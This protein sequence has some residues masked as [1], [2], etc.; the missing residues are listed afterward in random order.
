MSLPKARTSSPSHPPSLIFLI[1]PGREWGFTTSQL[2][3]S[4]SAAY[5]I[6][7]DL[8][9]AVYP[10]H[11]CFSYYEYLP[12]FHGLVHAVKNEFC[13]NLGD[14]E[15]LV[16]PLIHSLITDRQEDGSSVTC[17]SLCFSPW[18]LKCWAVL[19]GA[20]FQMGT[21]S[22]HEEVGSCRVLFAW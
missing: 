14:K 1:L 8:S 16:H 10:L 22:E 6:N 19:L 20:Q 2:L 4:F 13:K 15:M 17:S 5:K 7:S 9:S 12:P 21:W 18:E 3:K 11:E